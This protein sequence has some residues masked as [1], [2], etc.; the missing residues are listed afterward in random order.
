[1]RRRLRAVELADLPVGIEKHGVI[2]LVFRLKICPEVDVT[3]WDESTASHS[4]PRA[5]LRRQRGHSLLLVVPND[6][7][8]PRVVP[9]KHDP[10]TFVLTQRVRGAVGIG[11]LSVWCLLTDFK[12]QGRH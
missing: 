7:W 9:F 2:D 4:T 1:M 10:L 6:K 5:K 3:K 8:A 11:K 12:G